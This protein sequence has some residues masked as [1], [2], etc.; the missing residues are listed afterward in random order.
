MQ[1][2]IVKKQPNETHN[3]SQNEIEGID[4]GKSQRWN[5]IFMILRLVEIIHPLLWII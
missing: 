4:H 2:E 5:Q 3:I 1:K